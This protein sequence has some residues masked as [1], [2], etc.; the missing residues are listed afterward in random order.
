MAD[1]F[2]LAIGQ[3]A[4]AGVSGFAQAS[5]ASQNAS[6][7]YAAN[8]EQ[9]ALLSEDIDRRK[10]ENRS[11][12]QD[13]VSD[14]VLQANQEIAATQLL[15]MERGVG[16]T[17]MDA[18]T[19]HLATMEGIDLSRLKKT[20]DS[21]SDALDSQLKAGVRDANNSNAA[22]Y[23][24]AKTQSTGAML[25]MFGSGLQIMSGYRHDQAVLEASRNKS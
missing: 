14:R 7:T 25:G 4:L 8:E 16:G 23:R 10:A 19:R 18:M 9:M 17:T 20:H 12:Y 1:P 13:S 5:A 21:Q 2:T 24:E 11:M 6:A 22:A 3:V 15:A